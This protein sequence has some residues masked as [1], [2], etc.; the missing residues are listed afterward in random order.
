MH[1]DFERCYR[2]VQSKDPALRRLVRHRRPDHEDL[3]PAELSGAAAL[4]A[5]HVVLSDGGR[6][7]AGRVPA[8]ASAAG[9]TPRRPLTGVERAHRR[10]VPGDAA[11]RRRRRR[12]R[13]CHRSRGRL[14]YSTRQLE[15]H[16][17]EEVGAGPLALARP[18]AP[19]RAPA[20]RD[21]RAAVRATL[22]F[23][24]GF[25][26]IRQFNDT[27]RT[28]CSTAHPRPCA[29]RR[30]SARPP[31]HRARSRCACRSASRS[32]PTCCSAGWCRWECPAFEEVPRRRVSP[33]AA[34]AARQLHRRADAHARLHLVPAH[35]R[36]RPRSV[37]PPSRVPAT[38][39]SRRRPRS[40]Q[41]R[42]GRDPALSELVTKHPGIRIRR[43]TDEH[44]TGRPR[45]A[46]PAGVPRG[47]AHARR[48]PRRRV[49]ARRSRIP[50]RA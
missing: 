39:G 50:R 9:P 37:T 19:D 3:L 21:D 31:R 26:S 45:R 6:R 41:R 28:R 20:D 10:R 2:A 25:A 23:G 13:R 38:V 12:P 8:P 15:R 35:P 14:G 7:A 46:R 30:A 5:E 43:T 22:A 18:G 40:R 17:N 48:S 49:P 11:H 1:E 27:V 42:A 32:P 36:R 16:L 47:G 4:Q 33:H 29:S 24:A 44:E 34:P